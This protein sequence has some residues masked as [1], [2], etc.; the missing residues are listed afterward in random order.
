MTTQITGIPSDLNVNLD[1]VPQ[2]LTGSVNFTIWNSYIK[3]TLD[4]DDLKPFIDP[5]IPRPDVTDPAY[6]RWS[7]LSKKITL[8]LTRQLEPRILEKLEMSPTPTIYADE[9]YTAIKRIVIGAGLEGIGHTYLLATS[10]KREEF[11]SMEQYIDAFR[12]AVKTANQN[13]GT[14]IPPLAAAYLLL[15]GIENELPMWV[16]TMKHDMESKPDPNK[17]T[18][19]QLMELYEK[20]IDKGKDRE[21][22]YLSKS[23]D[24]KTSNKTSNT[25]PHQPSSSDKPRMQ[26]RTPPNGMPTKKWV[27]KW[28]K[29]EQRNAEGKC[30]FCEYGIH[31]SR[32]CF[33]LVPERRPDGWKPWKGLWHLMKSLPNQTQTT[34][35]GPE[36]SQSKMAV[37]MTGNEDPYYMDRP[38]GLMAKSIS[39]NDESFDHSKYP[40]YRP[41]LSDT[42]TSYFMCSEKSAM[43][44][45]HEY[46]PDEEPPHFETSKG[47]MTST[48]AYGKC[49]IQLERN[50]GST[51]DILVKCLYN[52]HIS[53]NLFAASISKKE[54]GLWVNNKDNTVRK[55]DSDEI[56]GYTYEI[57][58]LP[59]LQTRKPTPK[60]FKAVK[61]LEEHRRLAHCGY[62]KL[63][64]TTNLN[65]NWLEDIGFHCEPCHIAKSKRIVSHTPQIRSKNVWDLYHTDVQPIKPIGYGG[66][67]Y[68]LINVNDKHRVPEVEFLHNKGQASDKLITFCKKFKAITGRYPLRFRMD[69]GLEFS[70]FNTWA[71]KKGITIE[72]TP[73][74]TPEPNGVA[75][76][77]AG[78]LNQTSRAMIIDAGLPAKLWPFALDAAVYT[79]VR[80][81]NR[82]EIKSPLQAYREDLGLSNPETSIKHLQIWG[83]RCYKHIP[84]EDRVQAEKLGPRATTGHLIGYEGENGHIFKIWDPVTDKMLR[85]RDVTFGQGK[86]D[87]DASPILKKTPPS[88]NDPSGRSMRITLHPET[89]GPI[90]KSIEDAPYTTNRLQTLSDSPPYEFGDSTT[91]LLEN[92]S[93]QGQTNRLEPEQI[94][95]D[96]LNPSPMIP[97]TEYVDHFTKLETS[98]PPSPQRRPH[99]LSKQ[100]TKKPSQ[101]DTVLRSSSRN[102]KGQPPKRLEDEEA[103]RIAQK[104]LKKKE[105]MMA[106]TGG[107]MFAVAPIIGCYKTTIPNLKTFDVTIPKTFSEAMASPQK[108]QWILAMDDQI[109]KLNK[110]HTYEIVDRPKD[111]YFKLLPGKW[112]FD[113][114]SDA[115]NFITDWRARWVVCGNY[116]RPGRDF[117]DTYAP[118]VTETATKLALSSIAMLGLHAEQVDFVTAFLN[119]QLRDKKLYM[120]TPTGYEQNNKV[121]LLQQALYGL[122]QSAFL[123]NKTIDRKLKSMGFQPLSEDPC[124][125]IRKSRKS[126][127][128]IYVDDAIIAASTKEEVHQIKK[129]LNETFP[130]KE[131]GELNKYLGCHLIRDYEKKTIILS[132]APY[133]EKIL[134]EANMISCSPVRIPMNPKYPKLRDDNSPV[135]VSCYIH[136]LGQLNWLST[137]SRP[138]IAFAVSRLQ[139]KSS[140][141]SSIDVQAAKSLFRY[142][143][144]HKDLGIT[145]G[146]NP[147]E[148]LCVY[149]DSSF[150][151]NEDGRSTESYV[152]MFAGAPISWS[153]KK[154]SFVAT[155][156]TIA[157]FCALSTATKEAIWL[158]KL[159]VALGLEAPG[160]TTIYSDSANAIGIVNKCG[161]TSTT[162]WIDNR[163]FFVRDAVQKGL[164]KIEWIDGKTN[165]AD[166]L[167]KPLDHVKHSQFRNLL[168]MAECHIKGNTTNIREIDE[169]FDEGIFAEETSLDD[170]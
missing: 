25:T 17:F 154:Q 63:K 137:K 151:D 15:R 82:N 72:K 58:G 60:S 136:I 119:G 165:P 93:Q 46:Q 26:K 39:N 91:R 59:Y 158:K 94:S 168:N 70:K 65:G 57:N 67:K 127:A 135:D 130:L 111:P 41:W 84:K 78:Y 62:P 102:T 8:W 108:E 34:L 50:D 141:P 9:A 64:A 125:Y 110:K 100:S 55:M 37:E 33:Y 170:R 103:E 22:S 76:R 27:E 53:C 20:A 24:K 104:E 69:G 74:R 162:K 49:S 114:K 106:P 105:K 89:E 47:D 120:R 144:G 40:T 81:V 156:S 32:D 88:P 5:T 142:L 28:L 122:R 146:F 97:H 85:S 163:Y 38:P 98:R 115:N 145:L 66:I 131:M 150:A 6:T 68:Y 149:V 129:E 116:Q 1:G 10:M 36:S 3:R 35:Q 121:C 99:I 126:F 152:S 132:Q 16:T 160:P 101:F 92:S 75:E 95:I 44:E 123:W 169:G 87:N 139:R 13:S 80:I 161:Y 51:Y 164:V 107:A 147:N 4:M 118:V 11:G 31:D 157:E 43:V 48:K 155:S 166:G 21:H 71:K 159:T 54:L 96:E 42:A 79:V 83:T 167:T 12:K 90:F 148:G 73:P 23:S 52:P 30:S 18:E 113:T 61:A 128:I 2:L 124:V 153:S 140:K 134:A 133:V 143:K 77:Y 138:D 117:D 14:V 19:L 112:V 109:T 56:V 45:Y 86:D 29:G 7:K